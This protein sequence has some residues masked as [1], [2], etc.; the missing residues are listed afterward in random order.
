[1][2]EEMERWFGSLDS[3]EGS[4]VIEKLTKVRFYGNGLFL[5]AV[6]ICTMVVWAGFYDVPY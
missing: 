6:L 3:E 4:R 1:M 5:V 2:M